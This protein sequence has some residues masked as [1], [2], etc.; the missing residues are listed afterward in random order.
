MIPH[1]SQATTIQLW[2][3]TKTTPV[4]RGDMWALGSTS[5]QHHQIP[6]W[7]KRRAQGTPLL[8]ETDLHDRKSASSDD[9]LTVVC[10][11]AQRVPSLIQTT[12]LTLNLPRHDSPSR[13]RVPESSCRLPQFVRAHRPR[14]RLWTMPSTFVSNMA[15]SKSTSGTCPSVI[16]DKTIC[17]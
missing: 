3:T 2:T 1:S 13:R 7:A 16:S 4:E 10:G 15:L 11:W 9:S 6:L 8:V 17:Y 14:S 12:A 5:S